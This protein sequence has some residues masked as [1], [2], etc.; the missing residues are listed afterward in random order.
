MI[1]TAFARICPV[2]L[3]FGLL[4][5]GMG[6]QAQVP[7]VREIEAPDWGR[8]GEDDLFGYALA[9]DGAHLIVGIPGAP[10]TSAPGDGMVEVYEPSPGGWVLRQ[11]LV[12]AQ[13]ES[14]EKF[15]IAI[16][17]SGDD[18][19]VGSWDAGFGNGL[20]PGSAHAYRRVSG[21]WQQLPQRLAPDELDADDAFGSVVAVSG[22]WLAV[23]APRYDDDTGIRGAVF[24]YRR[25]GT[26]WE[27]AQRI[28]GTDSTRSN[29]FSFGCGMA[30]ATDRLYIGD[31]FGDSVETPNTGA[32]H[33]YQLGDNGATLIGRIDV[34]DVENGDDYG[35]AIAATPTH[36]I[37][38]A[39]IGNPA[40]DNRNRVY[41]FER[42]TEGHS[43]QH[44]QLFSSFAVS[45]HLTADRALIAGPV[46]ESATTPGRK[47]SCVQR[48]DRNGQSWALNVPYLQQPEVGFTGFG[49]S[50]TADAQNIHVGHPFRDM[51]AGPSTGAISS[52]DL[53]APGALPEALQLPAGLWRFAF[54]TAVEGNFMVAT[55][56][57][58]ATS[59]DL[60]EGSAWFFDIAGGS[61]QL[62][63]RIDTPEPYT[64]ERFAN[65]VAIVGN[66]VVFLASRRV[67]GG[68]TVVL[69]TYQR[70]GNAIDF[71]DEF[72]VFSL[73]E[74]QDMQLHTTF[75]MSG[76]RLAL[77][78]S[79]ETPRGLSPRIAVL[80]RQGNTWQLE[81]MLQ[82]PAQDEEVAINLS[83]LAMHGDRIALL[84]GDVPAAPADPRGWVCFVYRRAGTSWN[85][86]QALR[87]APG[88]PSAT[89]LQ[90]LAIHGDGIALTTGDTLQNTLSS[91][92]HTF[93][94]NGSA[95]MATG[96]ID[97]PEGVSNFGR[98]LALE[99]DALVVE[100]FP[101][102]PI[103]NNF[104]VPLRL[105]RRDGDSW[106]Q[107]G[108]FLPQ[109]QA[110]AGEGLLFDFG[111]PLLRDG[112]L[113]AGGRRDG[114]SATTHTHGVIIE[115]DVSDPLFA[116]GLE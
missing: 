49:V 106:Y 67:E 14:D 75:N 53:A 23:S 22:D 86:E 76:D 85:L 61:A 102:A 34:T 57:Q 90:S 60:G 87:P 77:R 100:T 98:H 11:R 101:L 47:V 1:S 10:T 68:R 44:R 112:R 95:W 64:Y 84:R 2:L 69:R 19:V 65:D 21:S 38:A 89:V 105:Y 7:P 52:F 70:S 30:M 18:L 8:G 41:L 74:L 109:L 96:R 15:G 16:A 91:R 103:S 35:Y 58:L 39:A 50:V 5:C 26:A 24:L 81:A 63:A 93:R 56:P 72:D 107:A 62:L 88:D 104:V 79:V 37:V 59:D 80:L 82:P 40:S 43:L 111:L 114:D 32:V 9:M 33:W 115:F 54:N 12:P 31:C 27:L 73:P 29:G 28:E 4:Y 92:V 99:G 20:T 71:I 3:F 25:N 108:S 46:C 110:S 13:N 36:V 78:A 55:D 113:F 6:A 66:R 48:L 83:S 45:L 116:D 17:Q 97:Q 94:F 42:D 51:E